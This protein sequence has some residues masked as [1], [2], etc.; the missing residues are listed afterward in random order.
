MSVRYALVVILVGFGTF[1]AVGLLSGSAALGTA[2]SGC[3]VFLMGAMK[4]HR[5]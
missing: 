4:G 1:F 5:G 2:V 3:V